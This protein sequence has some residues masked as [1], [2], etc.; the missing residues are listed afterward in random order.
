MVAVIVRKSPGAGTQPETAVSV[1]HGHVDRRLGIINGFAATV[2]ATALDPLIGSPGVA[3]VTQDSSVRLLGDLDGHDAKKDAGS[4]VMLAQE[5]TGAGEFWND[6]HTGRGVDVAL[7]DSGVSPVEGLRGSGKVINGADLSF[8]SQS[9]DLRYMD[10][11]GH[12]THMAGIIAGRDEDAKSPIQKGDEEHFLG[13]APDARIVNVKVADTFGATDVSQVIAAID[14]VVTHRNDNG[15]NIRV[16]NL[17]FGTDA[18]QDYRLDPLAYA[19]EVAWRKGIVVVVSAGNQGYGN[20]GLNDPAIDPY[21]IV[22]GAADAKGTW[23]SHD[24]RLSQFSS[25]GDGK[26]RPDLL[27]PGQSVVSLRVPGS[28]IDQTYPQGRVAERFFRGS[29]TSQAAAVVSGAAALIISQRPSIKPDEVKALLVGTSGRV[30]SSNGPGMLDLKSAK[31]RSTPRSTQTWE[32]STGTGSLEQARGSSHLT[33]GG[34]VLSGEKDIFGAP[35]SGN[36]W[37]SEM[38][39]GTSWL[40]GRWNGNDWTGT[41]W[42]NQSWTGN[43]W[44]SIT[45]TAPAWSGNRWSGNRW[46]GN[47]WSGDGWSGGAWSGNRWSSGAWSADT[48]SSA[49]WGS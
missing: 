48:W 21:V 47:R 36:R 28:Y 31:D 10:S 14:W 2:P 43:S 42:C 39:A 18:T 19:A 17:S 9:Q 38:W 5:V 34:V 25:R 7:I 8:D 45:W 26:R 4:M 32:Q 23:G 49:G 29:G 35:W 41:C 15:M 16:L 46:S 40:G 24:D 37:S 27:A 30:S 6:G 1:L 22:V 12:G 13:M 33:D 3:S 11:F 44:S 20:A